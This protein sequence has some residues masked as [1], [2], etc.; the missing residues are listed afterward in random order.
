M[1]GREEEILR[2]YKENQTNRK[3]KLSQKCQLAPEIFK[4]LPIPNNLIFFIFSVQ[5]T[6]FNFQNLEIIL[7]LPF[8]PAFSFCFYCTINLKR[9]ATQIFFKKL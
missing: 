1:L 2:N 8:N 5:K 4:M 3:K 7:N 9:V 6:E